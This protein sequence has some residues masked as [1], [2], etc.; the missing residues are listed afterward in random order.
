MG[1]YSI[2]SHNSNDFLTIERESEDGFI[3]RIVRE[4]DGYEKVTTDFLARSLFESC[5]RT[6]YITKVENAQSSVTVA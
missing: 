4:L 6:G 3:V 2:K 5:L 1:C